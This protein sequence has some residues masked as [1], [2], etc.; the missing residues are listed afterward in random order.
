M[1][2]RIG[3]RTPCSNVRAEKLPK[4]IPKL[5]RQLHQ[6]KRAT[7]L[8][9]PPRD[10]SKHVQNKASLFGRFQSRCRPCCPS[11]RHSSR[12]GCL[13]TALAA[14]PNAARDIAFRT[15]SQ[16][17][18]F[19]SD[20]PCRETVTTPSFVR[21]PSCLWGLSGSRKEPEATCAFRLRAMSPHLASKGP[22]EPQET[23]TARKR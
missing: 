6:N 11:Y 8:G 16:T 19:I 22:T 3:Y 18:I 4:F 13:P 12:F 2:L 20:R 7:F 1:L 5:M 14:A 10:L 17:T 15:S 9:S 21:C 23:L